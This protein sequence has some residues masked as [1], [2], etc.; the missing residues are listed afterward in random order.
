MILPRPAPQPPP[1]DLRCKTC[2]GA[3]KVLHTD[4]RKI[5]AYMVCPTCLGSQTL[6]PNQPPTLKI[7]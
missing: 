3:G 5:Q 2:M 7:N 6:T 1:P 4:S